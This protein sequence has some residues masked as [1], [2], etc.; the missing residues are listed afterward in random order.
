V[1]SVPAYFDNVVILQT[2]D[3]LQQQRGG[4]A[5]LDSAHDLMHEVT[6]TYAIDD[7]AAVGFLEEMI[8]ASA[9]GL[10]TWRLM[11]QNVQPSQASYYL[12]SGPRRGACTLLPLA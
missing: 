1:T 12:K 5:L 3:R 11:D 9:A 6:G 10:L 7:V 2:L 8:T 4:Q